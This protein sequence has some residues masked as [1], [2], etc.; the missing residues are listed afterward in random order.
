MSTSHA[1]ECRRWLQA[2]CEYMDGELD[3]ELCV[4]LEQHLAECAACAT[5]L[6]TMR[7]TVTLYRR[8]GRAQPPEDLIKHLE[9]LVH[10]CLKDTPSALNS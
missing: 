10:R 9:D 1:Q 3:E 5:V 4:K 2:L 7:Q 8:W 6:E